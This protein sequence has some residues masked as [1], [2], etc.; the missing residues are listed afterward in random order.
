MTYK[1]NWLR[2]LLGPMLVSYASLG[3]AVPAD[4]VT[5]NSTTLFI[6]R[7]AVYGIGH[8]QYGMIAPGSATSFSTPFFSGKLD[9]KSVAMSDWRSVVLYKDGTADHAG[10][11]LKTYTGIANKLPAT[12]ISDVAASLKTIY[13]ISDGTL[14][15]WSGETTAAPVALATSVEQVA[16]GDN[17]AVVLFKDGTI[18]TI[19]TNTHGQLGNGTTTPLTT[20]EK[21]ND[22]TG[23]AIAAGKNTSLV[24]QA[25]GTVKALGSNS[26]HEF[27]LGHTNNV[28]TPT[29]IPGLT[30][31]AKV[32]QSD[33]A[34]FAL[35]N[36]G[37]LMACGWHNYIEGALYNTS[38]TCVTLPVGTS[39]DVSAGKG[40]RIMLDKGINGQRHGWSGNLYGALGDGSGVEQHQLVTAY[41]SPVVTDPV[42]EPVA[43]VEEP[44]VEEP[45][46][47]ASA[48]EEEKVDVT[49]PIE[50]VQP[51]EPQ[52]EPSIIDTVVEVIED[53]IDTVVETIEK[54]VD[55]IIEVVVPTP[56]PEPVVAVPVVEP[57]KKKCNNG[58][59]NGDQCAPG[60]SLQHNN[61]ENAVVAKVNPVR[62]KG[63]K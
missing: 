16:A 42:P 57:S 12:N 36:D 52:P 32:M 22:L 28:L 58:W 46:L 18:G 9:A 14:Y 3:L 11:S 60:K 4:M 23:V 59:G 40:G 8:N 17:H 20:V 62:D 43:M 33:N 21:I 5:T 53:V 2:G 41:F 39:I 29:T 24:L 34:V 26:M 48:P 30:N 55:A 37:S 13:Y 1:T 56:A 45:A 51:V 31:V 15:S 19:G 25:D 10:L 44:M 7:G 54:V 27:A 47:A 35:L 38:R 6:D 63:K 50:T 49:F 61:A